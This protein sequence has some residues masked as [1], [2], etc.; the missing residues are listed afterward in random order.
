MPMSINQTSIHWFR[1]DLRTADNPALLS[2]A[3]SGRVIP[4]YIFDDSIPDE[5][6]IS[7]ASKVWLHHSLDSL[8]HTLN[9]HL[10]CFRG[11]PVTILE[12]LCKKY[13]VKYVAWNRAYDPWRIE[14]DP[15]VKA[16]LHS[17]GIKGQ[18]FNGSLLWEPWETLKADGS[19]YRVFTPFYKNGCLSADAPRP[20]LSAPQICYHDEKL[21]PSN[22][23]NLGLLDNQSWEADLI[24]KWRVGED[25]ASAKLEN[26]LNEG[27][28]NYKDGR[29]FPA[30]QSVS[31][32]S[33]HLR[34]GEI[35]VNTVWYA[36]K[37]QLKE[38]PQLGE[39]ANHFLSELGWREFSYSLLYHFPSLPTKNL[40]PRFEKFP[41]VKD[42]VG[43]KAW[44]SG[45]T[46][47]PIVDAGM[48]QLWNIGYMH[49]RLRMIV[50]SFLVKNLRI[51][52]HHGQAW[53]WDTLFDADL[54]N[55]SAG[56]QWIAGCGADAAPYFRIFNPVTQGLKFDPDGSFIRQFVPELEKVPAKYIFDPWNAPQD[57]LATSGVVLGETYPNPIVDL[58]M[59]REKALE[60][61]ATLKA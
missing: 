13:N 45:R 16:I 58:K 44:K 22:L 4:V 9:G 15:K 6:Q 26:F 11:N 40:N 1:Q 24:S 50:G 30:Q 54:A 61:F 49:N 17:I 2:A 3:S 31:G 35:S 42:Q 48:R 55:N 36:T 23:D 46:G 37:K 39:N 56:W 8:N 52:W 25:G 27:I 59:S 21:E 20:P 7:G 51:H 19:P 12:K 33:P 47:I 5:L 43:L 14:Q 60:A 18:S 29:N 41:W 34:W 28:K 57:I 38:R 10:R 53:F 32:L